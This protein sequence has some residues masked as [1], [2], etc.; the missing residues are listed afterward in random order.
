MTQILRFGDEMMT[1]AAGDPFWL[2]V[3]FVL[4]VDGWKHD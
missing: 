1:S 4:A 3:F 2:G